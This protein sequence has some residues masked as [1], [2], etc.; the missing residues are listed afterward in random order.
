MVIGRNDIVYLTTNE[1]EQVY[2]ILDIV[3]ARDDERRD[4]TMLMNALKRRGAPEEQ[5]SL[6]KPGDVRLLLG[7][8][9]WHSRFQLLTPDTKNAKSLSSMVGT[10]TLRSRYLL[11]R[12]QLVSGAKRQL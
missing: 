6:T 9:S 2:A 10:S 1:A 3:T 4:A 11:P 5:M 12:S 7:I 8:S